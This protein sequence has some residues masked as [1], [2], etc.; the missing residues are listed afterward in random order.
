MFT[1]LHLKIM[2]IILGILLAS[3]QTMNQQKLNTL[4][5]ETPQLEKNKAIKLVCD[6]EVKCLRR[7]NFCF[8]NSYVTASLFHFYFARNDDGV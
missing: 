6:V 5:V 7:R 1:I 2:K 3:H 4:V 8:H